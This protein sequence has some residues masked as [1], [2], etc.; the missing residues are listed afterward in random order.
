V[1]FIDGIQESGESSLG[2]PIIIGVWDE[3]CEGDVQC[4]G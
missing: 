1:N 3:N 4:W 2:P